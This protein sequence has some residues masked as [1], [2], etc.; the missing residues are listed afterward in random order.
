[1]AVDAAV[2]YTAA[3]SELDLEY[4]QERWDLEEKEEEELH[5]SRKIAFDYMIDV[6]RKYDLPGTMALSEENIEE[7]VRRK[8]NTNIDQKIQFLE[9]NK[10]IYKGYGDYWLTLASAYFSNSDYKKCIESIK[11]YEAL[12]NTIFR[13]DYQYAKILPLAIASAEQ[14]YEVSEFVS[15]TENWIEKIIENTKDSHWALRYF[16][17][18]M[19]VDL[20]SKT[21]D[22]DYLRRA[23]D[24]IKNNINYLV[25]IQKK[26]N[27]EFLG[28]VQSLEIP[29]GTTKSKQKEINNINKM[30]KEERKTIL[31]PVYEPFILNCD[32]LF[33]LIKELELPKSERKRINGIIHENEEPIFLIDVVDSMYWISTEEDDYTVG[34]ELKYT[35]FNTLFDGHELTIPAY[36]VSDDAKITVSIVGEDTVFDD[37]KVKEV[38]RKNPKDYTSFTATFSSDLADEYSYDKDSRV[39]IRIVPKNGFAKQAYQFGMEVSSYKESPIPIP[40]FTTFI[41]DITFKVVTE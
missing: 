2:N 33:G 21:S 10:S 32:F 41:D 7:Y 15:E 35:S 38:K 12:G 39:R 1:M 17:A 31:P 8:N 23:Y 40:P 34:N 30:L 11:E 16:A 28:P 9:T 13:K 36:L 26:K 18:Q 24:I 20:Y 3:M 5:N 6:V 4:L 29:K 14:E 22:K 37:W 25:D 27:E 19:C